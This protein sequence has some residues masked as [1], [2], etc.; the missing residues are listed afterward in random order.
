MITASMQSVTRSFGAVLAFF[1][2][3]VHAAR[4]SAWPHAR[5]EEAREEEIYTAWSFF[6]FLAAGE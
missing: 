2:V 3:V 5:L 6:F 1:F 4:K